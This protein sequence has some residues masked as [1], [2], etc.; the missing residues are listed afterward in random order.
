MNETGVK[1]SILIIDDDD[2]ILSTLTIVLKRYFD[3]VVVGN[4]PHKITQFLQQESFGVVLLDMNFVA[5]QT[6]GKE[7][8]QWLTHIQTMAPGTSPL[9]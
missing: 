2:G 3:R 5:G 4:T 1:G 8:F 9:R 7:G 6:S